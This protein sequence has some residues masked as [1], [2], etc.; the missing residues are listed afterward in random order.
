MDGEWQDAVYCNEAG[1]S[2]HIK[3]MLARKMDS[4]M[5]F[6]KIKLA[7]RVGNKKIIEIGMRSDGRLYINFN[8]E[9]VL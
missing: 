1:I 7:E 3:G 4:D 9:V 8:L 5:G 2:V 6:T